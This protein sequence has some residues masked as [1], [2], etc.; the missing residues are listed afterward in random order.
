MSRRSNH[1]CL[2]LI[3]VFGRPQARYFPLHLWATCFFSELF[4]LIG[5]KCQ[6]LRHISCNFWG[7]GAS[8]S[9]LGRRRACAHGWQERIKIYQSRRESMLRALVV[10]LSVSCKSRVAPKGV[11][12]I[13]YNNDISLHCAEG[14]LCASCRA[15]CWYQVDRVSSNVLCVAPGS[16]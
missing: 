5:S 4:D 9:A 10:V 3:S 6:L 16:L 11:T 14:K 2:Y 7:R 1:S 12:L 8:I 15:G 13:S